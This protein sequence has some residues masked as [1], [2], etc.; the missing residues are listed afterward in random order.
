M[1]KYL[2]P[3]SARG[4]VGWI[5]HH[6]KAYEQKVLKHVPLDRPGASPDTYAMPRAEFEG[7][8]REFDAYLAEHLE[9]HHGGQDVYGYHVHALSA[10]TPGQQLAKR[11]DVHPLVWERGGFEGERAWFGI[12]GCIKAD[13]ILTA[14]LRAGEP[15]AVFSV[16]SVSLWEA[17]YPAEEAELEEG[18]ELAAFAV[19]HLLG[20]T[21][22]I[23]PDA[24]AY[25]KDEVMTQALLCRSTL[26]RLGL[27]AE[28][29]LPPDDRLD[30][31]IKGVDDYLGRGGGTLDRM[32]WYRKEPP[33]EEELTEWL[34]RRPG[35][36]SWKADR[37]RRAAETLQALVTHAGENGEYS[38][39][40][41]LLSRAIARRGGRP[42]PWRDDVEA[43]EAAR[44]RDPEA[45]RKR[46]ERGVRDLL[47]VDAISSNKP[48]SVR[49]E[50]WLRRQSGWHLEQGLHWAEDGVVITVHEELRAPAER[51]SV[52]DL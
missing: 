42:Q 19:R 45:T 36:A 38:T 51:R 20:R 39:S 12:E 37:R 13:A 25:A 9:R 15:P 6:G 31:G 49:Q 16:P 26:R 3:P 7:L 43:L 10:K 47:D 11:I 52:K 29:V 48:L 17:T 35:A 50:G 21:V 14:L 40:V 41:R 24:D 44:T 33:D 28:I 23:V 27:R 8:K 34:V 5:D 1:A 22:C 18:D 2:F 46:F 4:L 32:V 30:E